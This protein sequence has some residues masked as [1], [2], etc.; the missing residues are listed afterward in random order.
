MF[1]FLARVV[2]NNATAPPRC[3]ASLAKYLP[4]DCAT[5]R[6]AMN[7]PRPVPESAAR[8]LLLGALLALACSTP[9]AFTIT[10]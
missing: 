8:V 3:F 7:V 10:T 5:P 2:S 4:R 1:P 6:I 9:C